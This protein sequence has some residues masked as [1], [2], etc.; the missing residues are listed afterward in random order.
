MKL[1][2]RFT[3]LFGEALLVLQIAQAL[4]HRELEIL[5]NQRPIHI[6]LVK[7]DDGGYAVGLHFVQLVSSMT[8]FHQ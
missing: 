4:L 5:T 6:A 1:L 2:A 8:H 3:K 7:L